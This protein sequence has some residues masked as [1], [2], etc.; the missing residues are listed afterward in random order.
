MRRA[1]APA[2][3]RWT[4]GAAW[5]I[6]VSVG[7][8]ASA[9]PSQ[10]APK[11]HNFDTV[12]LNFVD[13]S[14]GEIVYDV[15]LIATPGL[16]VTAIRERPA[17]RFS[18]ETKVFHIPSSGRAQPRRTIIQ[19]GFR[20]YQFF[21]FSN[22]SVSSLTDGS[23]L[24]A[25]TARDRLI[26]TSREGVIIEF[27]LS[28]TRVSIGGDG[29]DNRWA[30]FRRQ[31]DGVTHIYHTRQAS[32]TDNNGRQILV[33]RLQGIE[34]NLGWALKAEYG[35]NTVPP[36]GSGQ[37]AASPFWA[38][39]R[40][41]V[42]NRGQ[43]TCDVRQDNC[44][45]AQNWPTT[46]P[47]ANPEGFIDASGAQQFLP[48]ALTALRLGGTGDVA[49]EYF[50]KIRPPLSISTEPECNN[51][52]PY[53]PTEYFGAFCYPRWIGV[54]RVM[55]NGQAWEYEIRDW[56]P[57]AGERDAKITDPLGRVTTIRSWADDDFRPRT[58]VDELGRT[59]SLEYETQ[60][61]FRQTRL[62]RVTLPDGQN[63]SYSYD[64][65]GNILTETKAPAPALGG[66]VLSWSASYPAGCASAADCNKPLSTTDANGNVRTFS[67]S[68]VHGGL[69]SETSPPDANGIR[70]V[71][72]YVWTQRS[73]WVRAAGGG[74]QPLDP[75]WLLAEERTCRTTATNVSSGVCA[76]GAGDEVVTRYEYGPDSGPNNLLLRGTSVTADGT[77]LRTCYSYDLVGNRISETSPRAGLG[78]CP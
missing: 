59:T 40:L 36:N 69:L 31:P 17:W 78:V 45:F 19:D 9:Q 5:V 77:T 12:D 30:F 64:A 57:D 33:D 28:A 4:V 7:A 63:V 54:Q 27:P 51:P 71:K 72:R 73:A 6:A 50:N 16:P 13:R 48:T 21:N 46:V 22:L 1:R 67:Y 53:T 41:T 18:Y 61:S 76:G 75:V 34:T 29:R 38:T 66:P 35:S 62:I 60:T 14:S 20:R 32:Y 2:T 23:T 58:I 70:P 52:T 68:S 3:G 49:L 43:D 10:T 42:F 8:S 25:D 65:R 74:F 26:F 47:T 39:I 44:A 24:R 55:R 11:P 15:P 37:A 56:G